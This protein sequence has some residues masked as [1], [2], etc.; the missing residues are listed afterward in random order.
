MRRI[1]RPWWRSG[2]AGSTGRGGVRDSEAGGEGK[3]FSSH[4]DDGDCQTRGA[5]TVLMVG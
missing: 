4:G 5:R 1:R 2:A 3:R